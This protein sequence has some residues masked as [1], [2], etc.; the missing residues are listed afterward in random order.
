MYAALNVVGTTLHL[1]DR[2]KSSFSFKRFV[3]SGSD[4]YCSYLDAIE[5]LK[6]C[7][8]WSATGSNETRSGS[9]VRAGMGQ[10]RVAVT[11]WCTS[12]QGHLNCGQASGRKSNEEETAMECSRVELRHGR[13]VVVVWTGR[14]CLSSSAVVGRWWRLIDIH[15]NR[16]KPCDKRATH[17]S[18]NISDRLPWHYAKSSNV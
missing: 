8:Q 14:R 3:G 5:P 2:L 18:I 16:L 4:V 17:G 7:P 11:R 1:S 13:L 15:S 9:D 10:S 6:Q 12:L